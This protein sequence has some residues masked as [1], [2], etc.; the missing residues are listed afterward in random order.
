MF[1]IAR[2]KDGELRIFHEIPVRNTPWKFLFWGEK[3]DHWICPY[4]EYVKR[5]K[6]YSYLYYG[7]ISKSELNEK[8]KEL[9]WEDEPVML[10]INMS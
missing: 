7:F 1:Y 2:N 6:E 8:F 9:K 5:V 3:E 10:I 4:F